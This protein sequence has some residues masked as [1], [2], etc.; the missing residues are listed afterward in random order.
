MATRVSLVFHHKLTHSVD[1]AFIRL[2]LDT[3]LIII[4]DLLPRVQ[5]LQNSRKVNSAN[6]IREFLSNISV[7]DSLPPPSPIVARQFIVSATLLSSFA[8]R[9]TLHSGRMHL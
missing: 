6:A 8:S 9:L 2:P 5:E 4:S 1:L 7:R 3:I